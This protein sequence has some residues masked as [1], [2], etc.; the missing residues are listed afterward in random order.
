MHVFWTIYIQIIVA[1]TLFDHKHA[2][3]ELK[4]NHCS[5]YLQRWDKFAYASWLLGSNKTLTSWLYKWIEMCMSLDNRL[6]QPIGIWFL[7]ISKLKFIRKSPLRHLYILFN[8]YQNKISDIIGH[9]RGVGS[10][11]SAQTNWKPNTRTHILG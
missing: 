5:P 2:T 1:P 8:W 9:F 3:A 11:N 6:V 4:A 10:T 7:K